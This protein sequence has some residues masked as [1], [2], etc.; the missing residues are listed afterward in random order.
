MNA[1]PLVSSL[2]DV[3]HLATLL[4]MVSLAGL[5]TFAFY[6]AFY[7]THRQTQPKK[8]TLKS[9]NKFK[10]GPKASNGS[11]SLPLAGSSVPPFLILMAGLLLTVLP[12]L[13]ASNLLFPV[14]FVVAERVLYL[15]SMGFTLLVGS[16]AYR[17]ATG[18]HK[19][20]RACAKMGV[21]LLL[22]T[23]S[24]KTLVRNRDWHSRLSLYAS[25]LRHYPTNSHMY[26]NLARE[27]RNIEDFDKAELAYK[28]AM[29]L[30]P[31]DPTAFVNF[32]SMLKQ[33]KKY[34]Q[35]EQVFKHRI[36]S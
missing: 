11:G 12:F 9:T 22:V 29:L 36:N 8:N 20:L 28:Q 26:V 17:L 21:V 23:H 3:R 31:S 7:H 27:Y 35:S 30:A 2:W 10:D 14:G 16:S 34:Q 1:I 18:K 25:V 5:S 6:K 24:G 32:G 15:P 4:T 33:L 13:P 19:L